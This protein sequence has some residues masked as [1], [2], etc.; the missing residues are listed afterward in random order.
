M[1]FSRT[2]LVFGALAAFGLSGFAFGFPTTAAAATTSSAASLPAGASHHGQCNYDPGFDPSNDPNCRW[3]HAPVWHH[4][5]PWDHGS[6]APDRPSG[7]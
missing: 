1:N 2:G 4:G 5:Y 3:Q 7:A 6:A